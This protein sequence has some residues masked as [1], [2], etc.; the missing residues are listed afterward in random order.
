[1]KIGVISD[2]HMSR[3]TEALLS[4]V[5]GIFSD[6]SMILHAGDLT[7]ISVLDAFAGKDVV[8]V[9]G[10][11]DRGDVTQALPVKK[12]INV[13]GNRIGLIHGWGSPKGVEARI[14]GEFQDVEAIVYGHTHKASNTI[15]DGVLMF[16]PGAFSGT[17]LFKRHRSVGLL[18]VDDGIRGEIVHL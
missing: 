18:T 2:T 3:P 13:R 17:L 9:C 1:M 14:R 16:N 7:A 4:L 6:V 10:N 8:A 15:K 12:I 5:D 11:M